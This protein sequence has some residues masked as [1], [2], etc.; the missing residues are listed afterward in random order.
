MFGIPTV[1]LCGLPPMSIINWERLSKLSL[2]FNREIFVSSIM[3]YEKT[4]QRTILVSILGSQRKITKVNSTV[5]TILYDIHYIIWINISV[6][7]SNKEDLSL[8]YMKSSVVG[9]NIKRKY[10]EVNSSMWHKSTLVSKCKS[11]RS[12]LVHGLCPYR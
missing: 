10:L 3:V 5:F 1:D 12:T 6:M 2:I 7:N 11:Q 4:S 9:N 8:I